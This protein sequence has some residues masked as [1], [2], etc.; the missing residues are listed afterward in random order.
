MTFFV[1]CELLVFVLQTCVGDQIFEGFKPDWNI[2]LALCVGV[3]FCTNLGIFGEGFE[4]PKR[5]HR[6]IILLL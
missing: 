6:E 1:K 3:Y 4:R 5:E 2:R